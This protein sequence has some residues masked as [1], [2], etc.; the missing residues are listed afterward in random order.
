MIFNHHAFPFNPNFDAFGVGIFSQRNQEE[1][2]PF[3]PVSGNFLLLDNT[4]MLLLDNSD[5]LLL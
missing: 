1:G 4:H 2:A 5:F 3:P